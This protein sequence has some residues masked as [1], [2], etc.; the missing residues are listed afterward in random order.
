ML[1]YGIV[2][3]VAAV[4]AWVL[5]RVLPSPTALVI[6]KGLA[7]IG[8][9]LL[10]IALVLLLIPPTGVEIAEALVR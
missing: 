2:F 4:I 5:G 10:F 8:I 3:L 9:I 6:A 7:A 1:T